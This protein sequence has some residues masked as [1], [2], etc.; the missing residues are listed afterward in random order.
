MNKK[1]S[2]TVISGVLIGAVVAFL[3]GALYMRCASQSLYE[4][5]VSFRVGTPDMLAIK[6]PAPEYMGCRELL[7]DAICK[8]RNP[9]IAQKVLLECKKI[10]EAEF[11]ASI[12]N[13]DEVLSIITNARFAT[14]PHLNMITLFVR[15][16]NPQLSALLAKAY[17]SAI[18]SYME[19]DLCNR[20][21]N[22][23]KAYRK[24]AE[25]KRKECENLRAELS[26]E[27]AMVDAKSREKMQK[28]LSIAEESYQNILN[29][30][31]KIETRLRN[32]ILIMPGDVSEPSICTKEET[33]SVFHNGREW[34]YR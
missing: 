19:E 18:V 6:D 16:E 13:D 9:S 25:L 5:S 17:L 8:W 29:G 10:R 21:E 11:D 3:I 22:T 7:D 1:T 31:T 28:E 30:I 27:R 34:F 2:V 24:N 20:I 15:A 32:R 26:S 14:I 12:L 4:V 23:K 33:K